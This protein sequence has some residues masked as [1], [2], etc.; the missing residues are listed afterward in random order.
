MSKSFIT[1]AQRSTEEANLSKC[2]RQLLELPLSNLVVCCF[3]LFCCSVVAVVDASNK[4]T[5]NTL[6][7]NALGILKN[8]PNLP[9][10]LVLNKVLCVR[11]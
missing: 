5:R 6:D 9:A 1:G 11:V 7:Q 3:F 8:H 10:T 2:T 4:R